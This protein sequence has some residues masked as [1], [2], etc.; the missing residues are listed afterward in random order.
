LK[1]NGI[2]KIDLSLFKSNEDNLKSLVKTTGY[3]IRN[4]EYLSEN[5]YTILDSLI[6]NTN[7][8]YNLDVQV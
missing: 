8:I 5:N 7:T 3:E 6:I 4:I 2:N 1:F